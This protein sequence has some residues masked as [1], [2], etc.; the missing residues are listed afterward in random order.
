LI[1]HCAGTVAAAARAEARLDD[2]EAKGR[3]ANRVKGRD[4]PE[5]LR[6]DAALGMNVYAEEAL[7]MGGGGGTKD[8]PFDCSCCH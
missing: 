8:C 6:F 1:L 3:A 2:L 5:P 7:G 4:S